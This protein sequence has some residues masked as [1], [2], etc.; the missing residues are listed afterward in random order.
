MCFKVIKHMMNRRLSMAF[1]TWHE[2][3]REQCRM[4]YVCSKIV[5]RMLN[6]K[7]AGAFETWHGMI[8][9]GLALLADTG[10]A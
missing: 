4:E 3:A 7:R 1:D 8:P 10:A 5:K 2:H 9:P 6:A